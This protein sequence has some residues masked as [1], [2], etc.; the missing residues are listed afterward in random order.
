[1]A[2]SRN[3]R[4]KRAKARLAAKAERIA[5]AAL[6]AERQARDAIVAAN[7]SAPRPSALERRVDRQLSSPLG[8]VRTPGSS[9]HIYGQW[10]PD[11]SGVLNDRQIKVL[12]KGN[13]KA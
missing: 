2:S 9:A 11:R 7:L 1:M 8:R 6:A 10:Q 5:K 3:I 12:Q 4:R 13:S